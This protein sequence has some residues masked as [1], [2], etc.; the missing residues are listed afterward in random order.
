MQ[1]KRMLR[2]KKWLIAGG[3]VLLI[4]AILTGLFFW[5]VSDYYPA[6]E[7][8]LEVMSQD[9]GITVLTCLC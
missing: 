6:D 7:T 8:A 2:H 9:S 3:I 4:L 5:Y 1:T